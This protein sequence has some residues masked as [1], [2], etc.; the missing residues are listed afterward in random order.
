MPFRFARRVEGDYLQSERSM[1]AVENLL[2]SV[3][4]ACEALGCIR[5]AGAFVLC[6]VWVRTQWPCQSRSCNLARSNQLVRSSTRRYPAIQGLEYIMFG[7]SWNSG[8]V[9]AET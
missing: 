6:D 2:F 4:Y 7:V 1:G 8:L 5:I 9:I 3:R